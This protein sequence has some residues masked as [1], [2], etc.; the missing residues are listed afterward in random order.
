MELRNRGENRP[1][2]KTLNRRRGGRFIPADDFGSHRRLHKKSKPLAA[3]GRSSKS[4]AEMHAEEEAF[5]S[6]QITNAKKR[7]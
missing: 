3:A 6:Q 1:S 4:I 7:V 5:C 2:E